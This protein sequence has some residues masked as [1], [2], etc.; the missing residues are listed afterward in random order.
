MKQEQV[1]LNHLR[2]H[3]SITCWEAIQLYHVTRCPEIIR[4]LKKKGH[5]IKS[6]QVNYKKEGGTWHYA[7]YTLEDENIQ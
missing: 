3:G 4:R 7:V 6:E 1:I 2:K 5:K